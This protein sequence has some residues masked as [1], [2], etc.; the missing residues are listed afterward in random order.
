MVRKAIKSGVLA[1]LEWAEEING[2]EE[3]MR[4]H[5]VASVFG[6]INYMCE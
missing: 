1:R 2:A 5:G 3:M 6:I 4:T